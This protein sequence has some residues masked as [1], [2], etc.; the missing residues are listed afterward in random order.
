MRGYDHNKNK[1]DDGNE[2]EYRN[3]TWST[4]KF[5]VSRSTKSNYNAQTL[6]KKNN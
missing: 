5:T 4:E 1:N 6:A 2:N 3:K